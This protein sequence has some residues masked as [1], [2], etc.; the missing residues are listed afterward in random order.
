MSE[1]PVDT[2]TVEQQVTKQ[3]TSSQIQQGTVSTCNFLPAGFEPRGGGVRA[4][5]DHVEVLVSGSE[6]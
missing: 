5:V 6:D 1:L 3:N 2:V 4:G